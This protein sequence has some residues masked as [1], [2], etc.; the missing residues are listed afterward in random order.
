M[1]RI[2]QDEMVYGFRDDSPDPRFLPGRG[3]MDH[4]FQVNAMEGTI[5]ELARRA[6]EGGQP[7]YCQFEGSSFR[8]NADGTY[9]RAMRMPALREG[10]EP[11]F[12]ETLARVRATWENASA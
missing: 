12:E 9:E 5:V 10:I 2:D 6:K 4:P 3:T 1:A 8:I 11:I 7:V